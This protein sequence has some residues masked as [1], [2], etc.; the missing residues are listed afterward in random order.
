VLDSVGVTKVP[1]SIDPVSILPVSKLPVTTV[2]VSIL[3][4]SMLAEKVSVS[5]TSLA[6]V[7]SGSSVVVVVVVVV[8]RPEAHSSGVNPKHDPK[9]S[10]QPHP[11]HGYRTSEASELVSV[12]LRSWE[13][14][15]YLPADPP[16]VLTKPALAAADIR[17]A[18]GILEIDPAALACDY[19]RRP[20]CEHSS[21][22]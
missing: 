13:C 21:S 5:V 11:H 9:G 4:D 20:A 3:P 6:A 1:V 17:R 14:G 2:N 16:V 18:A 10:W 15:T 19:F 22:E 12:D 8:E 7:G